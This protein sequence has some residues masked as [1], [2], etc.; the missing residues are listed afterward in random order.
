MHETEIIVYTKFTCYAP[1]DKGLMDNE[2]IVVL[3][4][5]FWA[6]AYGSN[7]TNSSSSDS[8]NSSIA[9]SS[10]SF[11]EF[12]RHDDDDMCPSS[13]FLLLTMV[14]A[15]F[16]LFVAIAGVVILILWKLRAERRAV[17][18]PV[19]SHQL[20]GAYE[21]QF[22]KRQIDGASAYARAETAS[23][24]QTGFWPLCCGVGCFIFILILIPISIWA[25]ADNRD[26]FV[27]HHVRR[28][29]D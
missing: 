2:M 5:T 17:P 20:I 28:H 11:P 19:T 16:A 8:S 15:I 23:F 9:S 12:R 1:L 6:V 26:A 24:P 3:F 25:F 29:H 21:S 22:G 7:S 4:L 14:F 13:S 10:S 18:M 27:V